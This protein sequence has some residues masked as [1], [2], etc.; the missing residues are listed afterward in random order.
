M[1]VMYFE[2]CNF[3]WGN[4]GVCKAEEATDAHTD[5]SRG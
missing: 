3:P 2:A 1:M 4:D 5:N